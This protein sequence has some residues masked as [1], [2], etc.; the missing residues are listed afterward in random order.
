[1]GKYMANQFTTSAA[2]MWN[3]L[4]PISLISLL[5][6]PFPLAREFAP[7]LSPSTLSQIIL[8]ENIHL[9]L[10]YFPFALWINVRKWNQTS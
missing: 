9:N 1:M 5:S 4:H 3:N 10:L 7:F 8:D 2:V 6:P